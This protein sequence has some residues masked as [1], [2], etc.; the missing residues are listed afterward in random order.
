MVEDEYH[1][2]FECTAYGQVRQQFPQLFSGFQDLVPGTYRVG[3]LAEF[4]RQ[5]PGALSRYIWAAMKAREVAPPGEQ[6]GELDT[7]SSSD[8]EVSVNLDTLSTDSD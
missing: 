7:L 1:L 5:D 2:V 4:L 3:A 6:V 8:S